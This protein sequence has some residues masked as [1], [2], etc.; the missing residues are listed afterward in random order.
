MCIVHLN[1]A[2][3]SA[4]NVADPLL[5]TTQFSY[6]RPPVGI[7]VLSRCTLSDVGRKR[8][9]RCVSGRMMPDTA[10]ITC[11]APRKTNTPI[12]SILEHASLWVCVASLS[13]SL[14]LSLSMGT[15]DLRGFALNGACRPRALDAKARKKENRHENKVDVQVLFQ[16]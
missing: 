7:L 9:L 6:L 14:S 1:T 8:S 15:C 5:P 3:R 13:L 16:T 2:K 10:V 11:N 4:D 12:L